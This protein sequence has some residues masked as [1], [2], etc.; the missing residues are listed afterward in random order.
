MLG[1]E[2]LG[3]VGTSSAGADRGTKKKKKK[4]QAKGGSKRERERGERERERAEVRSG[5][6][7]TP[8]AG[9]RWRPPTQTVCMTT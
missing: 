4:N 7:A 1:K 9:T 8:G 6:V 5:C 3:D 2:P